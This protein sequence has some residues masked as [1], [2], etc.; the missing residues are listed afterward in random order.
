MDEIIGRL[1]TPFIILSLVISVFTGVLTFDFYKMKDK[2]AGVE[3]LIARQDSL[4][5]TQ[6]ALAERQVKQIDSLMNMHPWRKPK[7][8]G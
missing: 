1:R 3:R 4:L 6:Q 8:Y 2:V 7:G 5:L